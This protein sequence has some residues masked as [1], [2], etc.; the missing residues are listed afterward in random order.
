MAEIEFS[1]V[2]RACLKGCNPDEDT[3]LK[4]P[5]AYEAES[6]AARA[7]IH[8]LFIT[9]DAKTR[10]RRLYFDTSALT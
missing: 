1:V 3:L 8:W 2:A 4:N 9:T 10:L 5:S 7:T 6:N